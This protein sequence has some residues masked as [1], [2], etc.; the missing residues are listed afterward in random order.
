MFHHPSM[1]FCVAGSLAGA[2][3]QLREPTLQVPS[4]LVGAAPGSTLPGHPGHA[5]RRCGLSG[6]AFGLRLEQ[7]RVLRRDGLER[8]LEALDGAVLGD[9]HGALVGKRQRCLRVVPLVRVV[10]EEREVQRQLLDLL[11]LGLDGLLGLL[12]VPLALLLLGEGRVL[13]LLELGLCGRLVAVGCGQLV[14]QLVELRPAHRLGCRLLGALSLGTTVAVGRTGGAL[15]LGTGAAL[16]ALDWLGHA[17][18]S[19][20][21]LTPAILLIAKGFLP[22]LER[23]DLLQG[24]PWLEANPVIPRE[25]LGVVLAKYQDVIRDALG[26]RL[27]GA[28]KDVEPL[29][30]SAQVGGTA[31]HDVSAKSRMRSPAFPIQALRF[32]PLACVY[33][34]QISASKSCSFVVPYSETSVC[35]WLLFFDIH[36]FR[37]PGEQSIGGGTPRSFAIP[38]QKAVRVW[39]GSFA[40]CSPT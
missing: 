15:S 23:L 2:T 6:L 7:V 9:R 34:C 28:M 26:E 11:V 39:R 5:G 35:S 29:A 20:G 25:R 30:G 16:C 27:A 4:P 8:L 10:T 19:V 31:G 37:K 21:Y 36:D 18:S 1:S 17:V 12:Q 14:A 40:I 33:S 3:L 38:F 13:Q 24:L 22:C 32:A